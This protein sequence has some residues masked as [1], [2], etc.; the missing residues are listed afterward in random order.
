MLPRADRSQALVRSP[1]L[2]C[3]QCRNTRW[4]CEEHPGRPWGDA[5]GACDCCAAWNALSEMQCHRWPGAARNAA[6][7]HSET[8]PANL[9]TFDADQ[10]KNY[11]KIRCQKRVSGS[12]SLL[13]AEADCSAMTAPHGKP[14][15]CC[16]R[17]DRWCAFRRAY[18]RA[19]FL[20]E[21]KVRG[22]WLI[23]SHSPQPRN[24]D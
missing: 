19:D 2:V 21:I 9:R 18:G 4:V 12:P 14:S 13:D 17:L 3:T 24:Y 1:M 11:V 16:L 8:H 7:L 15:L 22:R 23:M 6:R 20:A 5:E 10:S